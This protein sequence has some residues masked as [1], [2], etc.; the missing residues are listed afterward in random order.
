MNE[1]RQ[2]CADVVPVSMTKAE[3]SRDARGGLAQ[4][5]TPT[6][7]NA[8][9]VDAR[10][11]STD[12]PCPATLPG[13][14]AG[15]RETE[16]T[17]QNPVHQTAPP[18][19]PLAVPRANPVPRQ[20]IRHRL[21]RPSFG[22][23]NGCGI[24][25]RRRLWCPGC[26]SARVVS[27]RPTEA[28]ASATSLLPVHENWDARAISGDSCAISRRPDAPMGRAGRTALTRT[29]QDLN[30]VHCRRPLLR[31]SQRNPV[32]LRRP[33]RSPHCPYVPRC[34]SARERRQRPRG[35]RSSRSR[36]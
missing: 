26:K 12:A 5:R 25:R 32:T 2:R 13:V 15:T 10:Q 4:G 6:G 11:S 7:H 16:L 1:S 28:P 21:T 18:L 33:S 24:R 36:A 29:E 23:F 9:T 19:V 22:S 3:R 27:V 14:D 8:G 35:R 17:S 20:R 30:V 34:R 31:L